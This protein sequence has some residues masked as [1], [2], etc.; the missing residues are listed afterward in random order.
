MNPATKIYKVSE[1]TGNIKA[2]LDRNLPELWVE[3]EVSNLSTSPRGHTYMTLKD[4]AS[5]IKAVIFKS[6]RLLNASVPLENGHHIFAFGKISVYERGGNYQIIINKWEP[7]GLGVL[8]LA[9]EHLK[10]R[11]HQEGLFDD[12]HKKPLPLL[13]RLIGVITSPTGAA[14]RDIIETLTRRFPDFNLLLYPVRVQGQEAPA[15]IAE[16]IDFMNQLPD[17][18]VLIVGRG[19]GSLEDLWAFNE[20]I[21][22]RSIFNSRIPV[23][24]AV[25]HE[26]DYTIAD[27]TADRRAATPS[28]AAEIVIPQR[29][30]FIEKIEFLKHT[31]QGTMCSYLNELS[32]HIANLRGSYVFKKPE[33]IL[34]QYTQRIDELHHRINI[35]IK[36]LLDTNKQAWHAIKKHL[37]SLNPK[38]ILKRGYSITTSAANGQIITGPEEL[39]EQDEILTQVAK[40]IFRSVVKGKTN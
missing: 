25:G 16:A 22:A 4:A 9:F 8:Q 13:P 6:Q 17:V 15:E 7:Q 10:K 1:L 28:I 23:I 37:N 12:R 27:F 36:H 24:S 40:G 34:Q 30:A 32:S 20:E 2:I 39:R 35:T 26:I 3:G 18:D 33:N 21:V 14:V 29:D 19:G 31:L 5:Q 11:L 38:T